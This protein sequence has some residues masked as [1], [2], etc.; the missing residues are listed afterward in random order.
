MQPGKLMKTSAQKRHT[1]SINSPWARSGA[2][3]AART[4]QWRISQYPIQFVLF[5]QFLKE[6]N[7]TYVSLHAYLAKHFDREAHID[8]QED[9]WSECEIA[10]TVT[11]WEEVEVEEVTFDTKGSAPSHRTP[12]STA[13][14]SRDTVKAVPKE[15]ELVVGVPHADE[16]PS[17]LQSAPPLTP[18]GECAAKQDPPP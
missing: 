9:S 4:V 5:E 6:H 1:R 11:E 7:L 2:K 10:S 3:K 14:S 8:A 16:T 13:S 15:V 12:P 18:P 17:T